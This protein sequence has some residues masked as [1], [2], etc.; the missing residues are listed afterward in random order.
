ML[1]Y[2]KKSKKMSEIKPALQKLTELNMTVKTVPELKELYELIKL[3]LNNDKQIDICIPLVE[4]N[5]V[6]RGSLEIDETKPT[7]IKIECLA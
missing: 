4:T 5:R 7:W 2:K 6:L 1:Y 3:Y